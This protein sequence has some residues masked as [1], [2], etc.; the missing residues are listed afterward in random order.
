NEPCTGRRRL[1]RD[2]GRADH[3]LA[4]ACQNVTCKNAEKR[5]FTG[6][7]GAD[8][9]DE[10]TL[11]DRQVDAL[12]RLFLERRSLSE[13]NM[14]VLEIDHEA[15]PPRRRRGRMSAT[16]TSTAVTR[17]RSDAFNPSASVDSASW[18]AMR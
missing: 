8:D 1:A 9:G 4:L 7:V 18:M 16:A 5:R 12:Q 11:L 14:D 2:V 15:A 13:D 10:G 6:T 3:H 17:L